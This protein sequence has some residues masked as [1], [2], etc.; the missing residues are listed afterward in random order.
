VSKSQSLIGGIQAELTS[1]AE[2][3]KSAMRQQVE[4]SR[5]MQKEFQQ[6]FENMI[7]EVRAEQKILKD[8]NLELSKQLNDI[9]DVVL[10]SAESQR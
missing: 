2:A 6:R 1:Q 10:L 8:Q 4:D 5:K 9:R 7:S 3:L